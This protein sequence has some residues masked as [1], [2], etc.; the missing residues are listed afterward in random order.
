M[1]G[2]SLF[3]KDEDFDLQTFN[4]VQNDVENEVLITIPPVIDLTPEEIEKEKREK[5]ENLKKEQAREGASKNVL[6][7][8]ATLSEPMEEE[9]EVLNEEE[10]LGGNS[11]GSDREVSIL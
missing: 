6:E 4:K 7:W 9:I 1:K 10:S 11:W 2:N 8:V 3:G 5:E